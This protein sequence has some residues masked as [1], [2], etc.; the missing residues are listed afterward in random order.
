MGLD[1]NWVDSEDQKKVMNYSYAFH[2]KDA[3]RMPPLVREEV[4]RCKNELSCFAHYDKNGGI[5]IGCG[6]S[7]DRV[8]A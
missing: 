4:Q 2:V 5:W 3:S 7:G 6:D 1:L 8:Y